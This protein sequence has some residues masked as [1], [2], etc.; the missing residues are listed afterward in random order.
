MGARYSITSS[1]R[2][3]NAIGIAEPLCGLEV[4]GQLDARRPFD[5]QMED[6]V[7]APIHA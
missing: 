1:A 3:S 4:E 2:T 5:R 7:G 6:A